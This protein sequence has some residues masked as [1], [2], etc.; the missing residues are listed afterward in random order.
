MAERRTI[1]AIT[2]G[3]GFWIALEE[4]GTMTFQPV[5]SFA[6]VRC[7]GGEDGP[8]EEVIPLAAD[9]VASGLYEP[10]LLEMAG[11]VH[12]SD[13]AELGVSLK[14]GRKPRKSA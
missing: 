10:E 8:Y 12:E 5:V 1:T 3:A 2:S 4:G 13:F 7:E 6:L 14:P 9:D 11:L